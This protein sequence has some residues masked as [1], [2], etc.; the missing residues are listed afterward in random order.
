MC[1]LSR[2]SFRRN[3]RGWV[4]LQHD[5]H[6]FERGLLPDWR[7]ELSRAV[8]HLRFRH[9]P[10]LWNAKD[11]QRE[12]CEPRSIAAG[13]MDLIVFIVH[14]DYRSWISFSDD[15]NLHALAGRAL[16]GHSLGHE[17]LEPGD[18]TRHGEIKN[19]VRALPGRS[20][21]SLRVSRDSRD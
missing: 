6:S 11:G 18:Q 21:D 16:Y 19:R 12:T 4:D 1:S 20:P 7:A 5:H 17:T 15:Q 9:L 13:L 10:D 3:S 14:A 2:L 8:R